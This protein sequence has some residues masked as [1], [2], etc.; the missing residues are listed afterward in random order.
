MA[1]KP[2]SATLSSP[3]LGISKVAHGRKRPDGRVRYLIDPKGVAEE[4]GIPEQV[5][6][7]RWRKRTMKGNTFSGVRLSP[8]VWRAVGHAFGS[9]VREIT[10]LSEIAVAEKIAEKRTELRQEHLSL[11]A[12]KATYV[13]FQCLGSQRLAKI[14]DRHLIEDGGRKSGTPDLFLYQLNTKT[15]RANFFAFVE[16][17]KPE[18]PLKPHQRE[19]I[20]F[21]Q[22]IGVN[23][24]EFRL[25]EPRASKKGQSE[26]A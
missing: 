25:V 19:E 17:K 5:V 10:K 14:L 8:T 1:G 24:R 13:M 9:D 16:V 12:A 7:K 6:L 18:E 21:L 23:A 2:K 11:P 22:Q 15:Q 20:E 4:Q 3:P 26:A